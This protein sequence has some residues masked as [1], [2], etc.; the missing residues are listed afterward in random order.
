MNK[1]MFVYSMSIFLVIALI[2]S[3]SACKHKKP[4]PISTEME[5]AP[6]APVGEGQ[7]DINIEDLLF[8]PG[9]QYGLETVYFDFD[10]A[11]LRPDA[12]A[13]LQKNAEKIKSALQQNPNIIIQLAGHCDE[14][15]TQEYNLALG[16]R[17]ALAV[18]DYLIKLG[19][20]SQNLITISYG[21]EFPADP[22]HNEAAWAKNRRVEFNRGQK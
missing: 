3:L 8:Q 14:R 5:T 12:I 17:R 9:S 21:E 4:A 10:S 6:S 1:R 19:V 20:P 7:P 16:E 15:G 13:T 22:G 2:L 11:A 18:R